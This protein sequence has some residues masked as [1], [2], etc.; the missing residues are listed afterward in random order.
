M[1]DNPPPPVRI[2]MAGFKWQVPRKER[3]KLAPPPHEW[4]ELER[5]VEKYISPL[6]GL[7]S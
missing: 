5:K 4:T 7:R 1:Q 6:N 3:P 2:L